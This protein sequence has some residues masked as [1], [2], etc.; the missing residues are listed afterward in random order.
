MS[1]L[2][3][4]S[5]KT[6]IT[7]IIISVSLVAIL[8]GFSILTLLNIHNLRSNLI[9]QSSILA[10]LAGK[11]S[12]FAMVF[13]DTKVA[14][15]NLDNLKA[16][17]SI[18]R[19]ELYDSAG[20]FFV[21]FQN[22]PA[23]FKELKITKSASEYKNDELYI[24][25][26]IIILDGENVG[27]IFLV[28]SQAEL[29]KNVNDY[30]I[31]LFYV[32][33]LVL[34]LIVL[35]AYRFQKTI[36]YPILKLAKI[37][38]KITETHDYSIR[39]DNVS[40][41]EVGILYDGFNNML[42]EI[43]G[44][45]KAMEKAQNELR[46]SQEQ[47]S[48]FMER[49]PAAAYIKNADSIF[50]YVNKFLTDIFAAKDWIGKSFANESSSEKKN[51]NTKYDKESLNSIQHFEEYIYDSNNE[52]K[53]FESWKFPL[54]RKDKPTM[55]G[56]ISI[57]ITNRKYAEQQVNYYVKE[58]ERNNMELEEFNYV[59]SHD[60]REPLRTIT[61]YCD[62]L[63]EDVGEIVNET[64]KEDIKF[65]TEATTRMNVLIQDLLQLSRAGRIEF[66]E[67]PVNL[68]EVLNHVLRD[69]E[70]TIKE[71]HSIIQIG[72]LPV[73]MGD[74]VQL[75][76][77]FQ[78]LLTNAIK[79]KSDKNPIINIE[80]IEKSTYF[81]IVVSD[82]GIGIDKQYHHQIFS[83]FKRL[84]TR[85]KYE[86]TGIGLAICKKIIERHGGSIQI[87]SDV[88]QGS[89]FTVQFKKPEI[90]LQN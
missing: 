11:Y 53:Y 9:N 25:E 80:T 4:L 61:S 23:S 10:R 5:L 83:A 22:K 13:E 89:K 47:F 19:A 45:E 12:E 73:I 37:T 55:I 79:F 85:E 90:N 82:N 87:E 42:E 81:E 27:S 72:K 21:S 30:I 59:A 63:S 14:R 62:L 24:Y 75:S 88:G 38:Q 2:R 84:H 49:L 64:V 1:Y 51:F 60:L 18:I 66:D 86:G 54:Y 32:V 46:E 36:S 20:N 44:H 34:V 77:V 17:E 76:R 58:L 65:I 6:K 7:I 39:I 52:L 48:T 71:T 3:K 43:V 33:L 35:L 78:N 50:L 56:G 41:D 74:S 68:N 40:N 29:N 70:L 26:P 28:V 57:D 31:W 8:I 67:K 15:E 69:I 16:N